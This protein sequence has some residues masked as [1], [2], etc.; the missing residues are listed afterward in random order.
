MGNNG[1]AAFFMA[2]KVSDPCS[3]AQN[4]QQSKFKIHFIWQ[5]IFA[6]FLPSKKVGDTVAS[7]CS[8]PELIFD[9]PFHSV[10]LACMCA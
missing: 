4:L 6:S 3:F 2:T 8:N 7:C 9:F 5:S 1:V 10:Q